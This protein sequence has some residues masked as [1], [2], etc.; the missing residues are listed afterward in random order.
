MKP[1]GELDDA[2]CP[3]CAGRFL[4]GPSAQ[5]V[6]GEDLGLRP[7][8]LREKVGGARSGAC[9][10]CSTNLSP[11]VVEG[12]IVDLCTGCGGV[13]LDAGELE[14]ISLGRYSEV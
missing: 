7:R 6:F 5:R 2:K 14:E 12:R 10:S 13:W 1:T 11:V 3:S 8:E 4:P 9:P